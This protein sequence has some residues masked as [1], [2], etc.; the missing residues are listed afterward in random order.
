MLPP[1]DPRLS[2]YPQLPSSSQLPLIL[3]VMETAID[4]PPPIG[5]NGKD[6]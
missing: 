3:I 4:Q 5:S 6:R 1:P 2:S